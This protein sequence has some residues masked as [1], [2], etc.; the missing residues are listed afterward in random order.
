MGLQ[1]L[2]VVAS[3]L[4]LA[5]V[6]VYTY[7]THLLR[8]QSFRPY[9]LLVR[10]NE[11]AYKYVNA[12][13]GGAL[14][15]RVVH[16]GLSEGEGTWDSTV[17][18][19]PGQESHENVYS[20][21]LTTQSDPVSARSLGDLPEGLPVTVA[22]QDVEG[23]EYKTEMWFSCEEGCRAGRVRRALHR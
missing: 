16:S 18:L 12:G 19:K 6:T 11:N 13:N 2:T 10:T 8:L 20:G 3:L 21:S 23:N 7:E 22:F 4:T 15:V 1:I 5:V 17:F 14:N 9:V